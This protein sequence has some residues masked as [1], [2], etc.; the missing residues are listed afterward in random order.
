MKKLKFILD[1]VVK[2]IRWV[3]NKSIFQKF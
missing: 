2:S 1:E 3:E